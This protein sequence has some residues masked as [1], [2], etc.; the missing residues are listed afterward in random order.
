MARIPNLND[1]NISKREASDGE[2]L[3]IENE[4]GETMLFTP[5][6]AKVVLKDYIHNELGLESRKVVNNHREQLANM[7]KTELQE[8]KNDMD[9]LLHGEINKMVE[10]IIHS[11]MKYNI[12]A[13]VDK[14]V[15]ERLDKIY[16]EL[17]K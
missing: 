2:V 12:E 8:L 9:I 15:K 16:K 11:V 17:G 13:E 10:K 7:V 3:K 14:R 6:E 5:H 1:R 4:H